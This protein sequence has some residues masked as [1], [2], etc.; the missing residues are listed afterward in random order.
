MDVKSS[1]SATA[2]VRR[3]GSGPTSRK[4]KEIGLFQT[5][6]G[7]RFGDNGGDVIYVN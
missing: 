3:G 4:Q 2:R 7:G 5:E 6:S 1:A